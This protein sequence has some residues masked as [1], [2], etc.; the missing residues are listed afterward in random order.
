MKGSRPSP[1]EA[2]RPAVR[3]SSRTVFSGE[4]T[5]TA[6][7]PDLGP[8]FVLDTRL[9]M[10]GLAFLAGLPAD[11][12]P[13]AFLDPQYRGV[14]DKMAYGNEGK[15][16]ERARVALPQMTEDHITRFVAGI[17]RCLMP[18]GHLF[19]WIDKFHLCT[20]IGSWLEGTSL[21]TV[22]LLTWDKQRMGMG[23]RTRRQAEYLV[24][25]Q[26]SPKRAKGVWSVHNIPDVWSEKVPRSG[27]AHRKPVGL[28]A[29]LIAA[30]TGE[31]DIV[32]DPAA[33]SFSVMEACRCTGRRFLGCDING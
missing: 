32:I 3:A 14:L 7:E 24:V 21:E 6:P 12:M 33:G 30:V 29:E 13:A 11:S 10:D 26:K 31:G 25:L 17:D 28:Q 5:L 23:Y 20:G 19:L 9:K 16:R 1:A 4:R 15:S 18:S 22:D 27:H 8:E 2:E